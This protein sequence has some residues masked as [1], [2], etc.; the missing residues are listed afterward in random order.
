MSYVACDFYTHWR[1]DL[2]CIYNYS[3]IIFKLPTILFFIT[4]LVVEPKP[5]ICMCMCFHCKKPLVLLIA[6]NLKKCSR[7]ICESRYAGKI[8]SQHI[9]CLSQEVLY[10]ALLSCIDL[11]GWLSAFHH[12]H[13]HSLKLICLRKKN[14]NIWK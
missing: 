13:L 14:W 7:E 2:T 6:R 1:W 9:W 11:N 8:M 12:I 3:L 10:T 4:F 5:C